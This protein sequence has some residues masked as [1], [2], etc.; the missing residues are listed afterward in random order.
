MADYTEH[1]Q[2]HQW[3]PED[4]FLRTDFNED[5]EKIDTALGALAQ[6]TANHTAAIAKLGNCAIQHIT[7]T[8][9]GTISRTQTFDGKP[10]AVMVANTYDG[11]SF[12]ACRGM[13]TVYPHHQPNGS[14]KLSLAW[15]EN[16]VTWS[17]TSDAE[18]A[19][20]Q[21][22]DTYQLIVFIDLSA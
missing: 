20:N 12:I 11:Y 22:G 2:L 17:H 19:L 16:A 3:E 7:Y 6:L 14:L 8:G 10:L 18:R 1:Y 15:G 5:H 21:T 13:T 4:S 9:N